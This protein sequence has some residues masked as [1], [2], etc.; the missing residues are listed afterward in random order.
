MNIK[1]EYRPSTHITKMSFAIQKLLCNE[2]CRNG[3]TSNNDVCPH[4]LTHNIDELAAEFMAYECAQTRPSELFT[5]IVTWVDDPR[6]WAACLNFPS[7]LQRHAPR[8]IRD[9]FE[10]IAWRQLALLSYKPIKRAQKDLF[11]QRVGQLRAIT[12]AP[13][14][15]EERIKYYSEKQL[16]FFQ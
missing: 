9:T 10:E 3:L 11:M 4:L 12:M 14:E 15:T 7:R 8:H 16:Q 6:F 13:G 5:H 2:N 1:A